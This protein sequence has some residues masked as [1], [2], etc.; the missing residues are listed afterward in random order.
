[1]ILKGYQIVA[2]RERGDHKV[3][4]TLRNEE[5]KYKTFIGCYPERIE[6]TVDSSAL[7]LNLSFTYG[8]R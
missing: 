4:I 8:G 5:G 1:M 6:D 7:V 2:V 3:D